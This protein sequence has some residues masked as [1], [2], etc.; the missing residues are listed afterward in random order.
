MA[1][2]CRRY[3]RLVKVRMPPEYSDDDL[4][5]LLAG[6]PKLASLESGSGSEEGGTFAQLPDSLT[7]LSL[8]RCQSLRSWNLSLVSRCTQLR[9]LLLYGA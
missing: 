9:E 6:L 3:P 4:S 8:T 7:R 1:E 2:L 5:T